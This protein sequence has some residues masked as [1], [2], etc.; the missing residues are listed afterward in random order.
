MRGC[1][2][3]IKRTQKEINEQIQVTGHIQNLTAKFLKDLASSDK[4]H[5]KL[6]ELL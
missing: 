3:R 6:E 5:K 2:R 4:I 1:W